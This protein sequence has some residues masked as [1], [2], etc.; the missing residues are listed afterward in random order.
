MIPPAKPEFIFAR[1]LSARFARTSDLYTQRL[2]KSLFIVI[3]EDPASFMDKARLAE[4]FSVIDSAN[5]L[6]AIRDLRNTMA[7]E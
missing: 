3:G 6:E 2:L 1:T 5:D 7:H 4:K